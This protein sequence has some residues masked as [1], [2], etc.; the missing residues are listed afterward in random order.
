MS[1]EIATVEDDL[2]ARE[3]TRVSNEVVIEASN[4]GKAYSIYAKPAD[5]LK[6][7]FMPEIRRALHMK[8]V[9]YYRDF[10]ALR[11]LSFQV[12]RGETVGVIGRNGSGK[13]TLLQL[14]CGTLEPTEGYVQ[15]RGRVAALLELGAGF[16]P[17]FTGKENLLLNGQVLGLSKSEVESRYD[18]IVGFADIGDFI[19]QPVKTYSSGMYVRLAFAV[20]IHTDP[21]LLIIDE[22]LAVGDAKFNAKCMARIKKL[23]DDGL[24]IL[25]VSHDV[26]AVRSLCDRSIWL[27]KGRPRM[28]GSVFAVTAQ[29]MQYLFEEETAR[30][31]DEHD[32]AVAH[33]KQEIEDDKAQ[34]QLRA[35]KPVN[36][37]GSHLGSIIA[38]DTMGEDG[39]HRNMFFTS[40]KMTIRIRARVPPEA[41]RKCA[42]IA[43][44]LKDMA[45]SDLLVGTTWDSP[46]LS[47]D[48][49]EEVVEVSFTLDCYLREGDYVLVAALE[50]RSSD[51]IQYF[52][53]IEGAQYLKIFMKEF[54]YGV[55][56]APIEKRLVSRK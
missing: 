16:N 17:E 5:R 18:D 39:R 36:H 25:F 14:V 52:E 40:E 7:M 19:D 46:R 42:S 24:S 6:Q 56:I 45:G 37:W 23:R 4:L 47:L 31:N 12:H 15:T 49:G 20:A 51:S 43:F 48:N 53:Y 29:Y 32:Q 1:S 44:S 28:A 13:S 8:Q 35:R 9:A 50:D 10:W 54:R 2:K 26:G 55:F 41:N 38:V 33:A 34:E 27:D 11:G 3:Q 21:E 30:V 22:A